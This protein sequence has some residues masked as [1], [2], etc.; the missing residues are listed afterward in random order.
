MHMLIMFMAGPWFCLFQTIM[1]ATINGIRLY[2][3]ESISLSL[4]RPFKLRLN[5]HPQGLD[6]L[7]DKPI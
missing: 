1:S 6:A 4:F 2:S 7:M 5:F 3:T